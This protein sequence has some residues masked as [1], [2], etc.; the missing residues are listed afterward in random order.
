MLII[1]P[2]CDVS[3]PEDTLARQLGDPWSVR[4]AGRGSACPALELYEAGELLDVISATTLVRPLLRGGRAVLTAA[5]PRAIA[6][7]RLPA[8][9]TRPRVSF[10]PRR[11]RA[12]PVPAAVLLPAHWCW[13][14]ISDGR[15]GRV[16]VRAG[17]QGRRRRLSR[18]I[19]CC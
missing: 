18:G 19:A 3:W 14:A 4:L 1:S 17:D 7:G 6:W 5:G 16:M 11:R 2:D 15:F 9:G 12:D 13:V 10:G 8:S